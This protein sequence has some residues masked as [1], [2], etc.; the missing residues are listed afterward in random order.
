MNEKYIF[1]KFE[2]CERGYE[3]DS[4]KAPC[5]DCK[6]NTHDVDEAPCLHC[7]A[8][9]HA[10]PDYKT[11]CD[12]LEAQ[13]AEMLAMLKELMVAVDELNGARHDGPVA[14]IIAAYNV[15][16]SATNKAKELIKKV[17]GSADER[18]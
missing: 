17:E 15:A 3:D 9:D 13:N 12:Q 4:M 7:L 10:E 18:E 14:N 6:F 5:C 2:Q 16:F 11:V 8:N 1:N